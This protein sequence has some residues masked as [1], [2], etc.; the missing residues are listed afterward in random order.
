MELRDIVHALLKGDLLAARQWVADARRERIQWERIDR[1]QGLTDRELTVAAAVVELL[2]TRAEESP[3][4][5]ADAVGAQEEPLLLD[6][7]L[8]EMP[9]S[10]A[11]AKAFAPE[12]L[13][14]RNLVA[15]PD[16]LDVA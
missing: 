9:R 13:R 11:H 14:K 5:W 10:L 7:G 3:P 4:S 6:P 1:P 2:A 15:L 12:P 16:F 8:E